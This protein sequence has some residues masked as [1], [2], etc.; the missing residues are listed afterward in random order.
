M[1]RT[2]RLFKVSKVRKMVGPNDTVRCECGNSAEW[3]S[4]ARHRYYCT[5]GANLAAELCTLTLQK[6]T[7]KPY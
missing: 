7:R 3:Y 5:Q 4:Q 6:V 1:G 2:K